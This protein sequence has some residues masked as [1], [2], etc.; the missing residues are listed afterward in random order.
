M[1]LGVSESMTHF[2]RPAPASSYLSTCRLQMNDILE[3]IGV[4]Q[5]GLHPEL[6]PVFHP[7]ANK[8]KPVQMNGTVFHPRANKQTPV[9]MNDQASKLITR[10]CIECTLPFPRASFSKSQWRKAGSR[11]KQCIEE[12]E[13]SGRAMGSARQ[14]LPFFGLHAR[15]SR[16]VAWAGG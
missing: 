16:E 8:Q 4:G 9:Q 2:R 3:E 13:S 14:Y 15:A 7:R 5:Q 1:I 12:A 11:C 10:V 6:D